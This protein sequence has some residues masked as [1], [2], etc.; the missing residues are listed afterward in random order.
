[1]ETIN[2][3]NHKD[4]KSKT[5]EN[6]Q[7]TDIVL[8]IGMGD[9]I[10]SK[11]KE[12]GENKKLIYTQDLRAI[13]KTYQLIKYA[14]SHGY[15]VVISHEF[16]AQKLRKEY[17]YENIYRQ[18]SVELRGLKNLVI[19]EGI[20]FGNSTDMVQEENIITGFTNVELDNKKT[21]E[22]KPSLTE[23]AVQALKADIDSLLDKLK[24]SLDNN[25][26]PNYKML[27]NNLKDTIEL[28]NTLEHPKTENVQNYTV[29][30]PDLE[31]IAKYT[32]KNIAD[33]LR[34][35]GTGI[36]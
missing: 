5:N 14:K 2:L 19:D 18:D 33:S 27:I 3:L 6:G 15:N 26:F 34:M 4:F 30:I 1:M 17:N 29:N 20:N 21:N 8:S 36:Y 22:Q 10:Y 12:G 35:N 13:G 23:K 24:V 25:N 7:T 28:L 16:N 9:L 31:E 32:S 11:L